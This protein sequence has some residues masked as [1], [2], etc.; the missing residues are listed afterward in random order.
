MPF[1]TWGDASN[2]HVVGNQRLEGL[3]I[4]HLEPEE[5]LAAAMAQRADP[6]HGIYPLYATRP[7]QTPDAITEQMLEH[8]L[9]GYVN[10][11]SDAQAAAH[12]LWAG[13]GHQFDLPID[14]PDARILS[15]LTLRGDQT[16]SPVHDWR[17]RELYRYPLLQAFGA[18]ADAEVLGL[19]TQRGLLRRTDLVSRIRLCPACHGA[20]VLF[21][22]SCPNCH[23][24]EIESDESIHCF[25][26]GHVA[27]QRA[28]ILAGGLQC[29][30]CRTR[31]RHIGTEYD[32]PLEHHHCRRC[33]ERFTEPEVITHCSICN[34][35]SRPELLVTQEA[36]RYT[37]TE[38]GRLSVLN[39]NLSAPVISLERHGM[40]HPQVFEQ[41]L[42]WQSEIAAHHTDCRFTLLRL[43]I[44][45]LDDLA[46]SMSAEAVSRLLR[47]L[48]ERLPGFIRPG[49]VCTRTQSADF[50][51][52]MPQASTKDTQTLIERLQELL[53]SSEA[54][55]AADLRL[56]ARALDSGQTVLAETTGNALM[57][58][59]TEH[60]EGYLHA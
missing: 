23:G 41:L 11:P 1:S 60:Q 34:H 21:V 51:V 55:H 25:T 46:S 17:S 47:S 37:V 50:W 2:P 14:T 31:L 42:G 36:G 30:N 39:H 22:D 13:V 29:P 52:L 10:Q 24:L 18:S 43:Q 5:L 3:V 53:E 49:D 59:L 40:L 28:F 7:Q 16:L 32:R 44:A 58:K 15:Y 57:Q 33:A 9:D 45:N 12:S 27:S 26:C 56:S 6:K 48:S 54:L 4:T 20:H 8:L 19:L 38:Y 35:E